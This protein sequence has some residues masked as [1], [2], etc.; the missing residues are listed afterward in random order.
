MKYMRID[1]F[2]PCVNNLK[3]PK[4]IEGFHKLSSQQYH[5][6]LA[7]YKFQ[8][9]FENSLCRDY[10]TEKLFRP[11]VIGSVPVYLGSEY[12]PHFMPTRK[13]V[14]MVNDFKSPK[15]LAQYLIKLNE[16][17]IMYD[18]YLIHRD[19]K[20][21]NNPT[22]IKMIERQPWSIP[23]KIHKANFISQMFHGFSCYMCDQIHARNIKL[24]AHLKDRSQPLQP[25]KSASLHHMNC[26]RPKAMS[27]ATESYRNRGAHDVVYDFG[28][29]EA[30]A[31]VEMLRVN[32]TDSTK[33][34]TNYLRI[35]TDKYP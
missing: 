29:D 5:H 25:F 14:I 32:E 9:A 13:A 31:L 12:A 18:E 2:G 7:R 4:D 27:W 8:I 23:T 28:L 24:K 16:N 22:L 15:Q 26:P 19:T 11:L 6:F 35:K 33:W 10:M 21:L 1:S 17:D 3:M 20:Q 34:R 30:K